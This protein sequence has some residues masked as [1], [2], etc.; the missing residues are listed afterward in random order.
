MQS[1]RKA[2]KT[3][4]RH[5]GKTSQRQAPSSPE[6]AL[7]QNSMLSGKFDTSPLSVLTRV[8]LEYSGRSLVPL[9]DGRSR[10]GRQWDRIFP[11][12]K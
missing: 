8:H 6:A 2:E 3:T 7:L 10:T 9:R 1:P 5:S 4:P 11:Y 12:E